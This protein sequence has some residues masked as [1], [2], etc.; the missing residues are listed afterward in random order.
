MLWKPTPKQAEFLSSTEDEVLY[1]GAA[2]GGKSDALLIDALGLQQQAIGRPSYRAILFRRSFPELRDLVDRSQA[3]YRAAIPDCEYKES[4]REWHFPSGAKLEFGYLENDTDRFRY[5]GRQY[6]WIGWD[7]LTQWPSDVPYKYLLSRLRTTD[8]QIKCYVRATCNPGGA[9]HE[10]VRKHWQIDDDGGP[11]RVVNSLDGQAMVAR[12]IPARLSDN[13]YLGADYRRRLLSL[14][15]QERRALLDGRW[16]IADI[17]GAIYKEQINAALV[18]GRVTSIPVETGIVVNT[19]WDLGRNDTT[20]VWFHQAVGKENRW[21]D[22]YENNGEGL[23]HY[24][25]VLKQKGYLYGEHYLPHDVE[26][27][28]L[29]TNKSRKAALEDMGVKP[30]VVVPRVDD[31]NE[32]IEMTRRVF[33]TCWFDRVRCKRGLD[34]L[35]AYRREWDEKNGVFRSKPLH[36]WASNGADAFR[37]FAQGYAPPKPALNVEKLMNYSTAFG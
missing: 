10:W 2:G 28:E 16:D 36:N 8:K 23:A 6:Q 3:L 18:Q 30:I 15:E 22:Y 37:Q 33:A 25:A 19:F 34:A 31:I 12:F 1:G 11:T 24:A 26:V 7:E 4:T 32:G 27:T 9:G 35:K 14:S 20:A 17:E 29:T 13:P 21:V 5:Q